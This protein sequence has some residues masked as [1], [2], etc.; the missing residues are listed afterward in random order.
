MASSSSI[1]NETLDNYLQCNFS[2]LSS[3]FP[4]TTAIPLSDCTDICGFN[5]IQYPAADI[6]NRVST[7]IVPLF[8]LLGNTQFAPFGASNIVVITMHVLSDPIDATWSLLS[9]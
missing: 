7:W 8:V 3:Q 4:D 5:W 6:V 9:R 2:I 1:W